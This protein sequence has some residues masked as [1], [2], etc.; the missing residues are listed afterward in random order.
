ME[1]IFTAEQA[2]QIT[3]ALKAKIDTADTKATNAA[4]AAAAAQATAEAA[5][6]QLYLH[7]ISISG[8]GEYCGGKITLI[9]RIATQLNSYALLRANL[10]GIVNLSLVNEE[11]SGYYMLSYD[12]IQLREYD[13]LF[14][15]AVCLDADSLTVGTHSIALDANSTYADNVQTL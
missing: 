12:T 15:N 14:N 9:N 5:Q 6:A 11:D 3:T 7:T 2:A 1:I 4:T 10:S 13:I 8:G